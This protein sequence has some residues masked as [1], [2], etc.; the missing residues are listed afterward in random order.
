M[1]DLTIWKA[2][3]ELEHLENQL[4]LK[5]QQKELN[6]IR[7]QPGAVKTDKDVTSGGARE[8]KFASY[9]IRDIDLDRDIDY[10]QDLIKVYEDY[11]E[12][13]LKRLNKY[14]EWEQKVIYMRESKQ[15]WINI[16]CATP[17]S[18]TTCRRIYRSYKKQRDV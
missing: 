2:K 5:L 13:E 1:E 15:P 9:V 4:D 10:I 16:A 17:F 3:S 12:K 6:F 14:G 8:D 7:T 11:I 18:Q